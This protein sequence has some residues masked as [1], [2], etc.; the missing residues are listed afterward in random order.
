MEFS[1]FLDVVRALERAEVESILVGDVAM[2]LHGVVRATEDVDFFVRPERQNVERLKVALRSVWDDP[3]IDGI[4]AEDFELYPTLRY[5]PPAGY[6]VID[7]LTRLGTAFRY[8]DLEAER[9]T[10]ESVPIRV[11]T[12]T[13]LVR[14][15]QE[16]VRPIDKADA[17]ALTKIYGLEKRL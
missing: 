3:E 8:E 12:P 2:S 9:L 4:S 6:F 16:T 13:T 17:A 15:K 1:V 7:I 14:M 11:A 5:G 10:V